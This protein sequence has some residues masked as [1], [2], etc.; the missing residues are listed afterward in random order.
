MEARPMMELVL[1]LL[2]PRLRVI[3]VALQQCKYDFIPGT[4]QFLEKELIHRTA[5]QQTGVRT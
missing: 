1:K 5:S 4:R 2:D 3:A